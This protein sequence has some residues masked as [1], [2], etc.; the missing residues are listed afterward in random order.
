MEVAENGEGISIDR[1][2]LEGASKTEVIDT[3]PPDVSPVN[4]EDDLPQELLDDDLADSGDDV[5][6]DELLRSSVNRRKL[7][8]V[9][10]PE[11]GD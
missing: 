2:S 9:I 10:D 4:N 7:R 8:M 3:Q 6:T 1:V 5:T 11:D